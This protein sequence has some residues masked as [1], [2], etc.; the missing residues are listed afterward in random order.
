LETL[1]N[2][3]HSIDSQGELRLVIDDDALLGWARE[4]DV[5][6]SAAQVESLRSGIIPSR[7][8]KNF[9]AFS[10]DDQ[11]RV[12]LSE[13]F[14]CGCGGLGGTLINL[15]A[16]AGVGHLR[17]VDGDV[18]VPSNLNRQLFC[19]VPHL[20]CAKAQVAGEQVRVINPFIEVEVV[21]KELGQENSEDLIRGMDLVLDAL[22]SIEDRFLLS[23]TAARLGIPFVHA[24]VAGW[25]GQISTFLPGSFVD[26]RA[27]YGKRRSRHPMEDAMGVLGATAAV[28][29]SLE[30]LEAL[31]LLCGKKSAYADQL[32]YFD[33]EIGRMDIIPL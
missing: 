30:A 18:F 23:E 27:I 22:D 12:C 4:N 9:Q 32:L 19:D 10:L 29:A 8:I 6:P 2:L 14:V 25:W 31:R 33:G 7:Y 3:A 11:I 15:L 26:L 13:V 5:S 20:S 1:S 28:I 16:R 24:A 21:N 17:L